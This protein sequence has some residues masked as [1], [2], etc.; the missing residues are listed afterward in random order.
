MLNKGKIVLFPH[1]FERHLEIAMEAREQGDFHKARSHLEEALALEPEDV[2]VLF[3]VMVV[4]FEIGMY[5][6][7]QRLAEQLL[8]R[9]EGDQGEVLQFYV[10]NLMHQEKYEEVCEVLHP[11]LQD[12]SLNES[13]RRE[14]TEIFNTCQLI[15][16]IRVK[17]DEVTD[18]LLRRMVGKKLDYEP[19]YF[20]RL[21]WDLERG[22]AEKQVQ[23]IR[24]LQ[25]S[26]DPHAREA[27]EKFVLLPEANPAAKTLALYAL[28]ELGC[29][30]VMMVKFEEKFEVDLDFLP[31]QD[32]FGRDEEP[33]IEMLAKGVDHKDPSL[34]TF[35]SQLWSE[36]LYACYPQL[37]SM[38]GRQGWA[39]ALH[40]V[41]LLSMGQEPEKSELASLYSVS[42]PTLTKNY[43]RILEVLGLPN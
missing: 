16:E 3:G 2:S 39:A 27:M 13:L 24:Q 34:V 5:R 14:F 6:E 29:R 1:L 20:S 32:E 36:F 4:T 22:D 23:A 42:I 43:K 7:S 8:Q 11:L 28:K 21:L 40:F 26:G 18:P 17:E 31:N 25:Y 10:L 19:E 15:G 9:G 30:K 33:V 12:Y 35:G 41:T 38:K 37:P